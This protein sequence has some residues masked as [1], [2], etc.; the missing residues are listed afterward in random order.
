MR[1]MNHVGPN[2]SRLEPLHGRQW[3]LTSCGWCDW[4]IYGLSK[5]AHSSREYSTPPLVRNLHLFAFLRVSREWE[6]KLL[7]RHK[8]SRQHRPIAGKNILL[9]VL[10]SHRLE[11]HVR[12]RRMWFV[13]RHGNEKSTI[14]RCITGGGGSQW[15]KYLIEITPRKGSHPSQA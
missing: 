2:V 5:W 14:C 8:R 3:E 15:W 13:D 11:F 1:S 7:D 12:S 4:I 9:T 6:W 10:Y